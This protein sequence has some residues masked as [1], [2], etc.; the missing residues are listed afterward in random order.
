MASIEDIQSEWQ[1]DSPI[2]HTECAFEA[3]RVDSLHHKYE[4]MHVYERVRLR[5]M[6]SELNILEF[7]K[8]EFYSDG[9]NETTPKEWLPLT[10]P[11]N[12]KILKA[13]MD[14]YMNADPDINKAK[15]AIAIQEDKIDLLKSIVSKINFRGNLIRT[16]LDDLK[17]K[18]GI[19]S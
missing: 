4:K 13:D 16:I 9:P 17:W 18:S 6:E 14:R 7:A 10:P 3:A 19:N 1:K 8:F 15:L 5:K 11:S 12:K 2:D